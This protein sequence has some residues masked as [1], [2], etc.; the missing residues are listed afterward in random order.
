MCSGRIPVA[1][2]FQPYARTPL[3]TLV[4]ALWRAAQ[5]RPDLATAHQ[6]DIT[7]RIQRVTVESTKV[8]WQLLVQGRCVV[9]AENAVRWSTWIDLTQRLQ[10]RR[11]RTRDKKK[12][13]GESDMHPA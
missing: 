7:Y 3:E 1:A 9:P 12:L 5:N 4:T 2:G 10:H 13:F 8:L 6:P 11:L